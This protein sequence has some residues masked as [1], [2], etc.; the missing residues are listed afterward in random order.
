MLK[1]SY[2]E[3][4]KPLVQTFCESMSQGCYQNLAL[5]PMPFLPLFGQNYESSALRLLIIGQDTRS[6]GNTEHFIQTETESPGKMISAVFDEIEHLNFRGWGKSTNSF[7]GF[8]MALLANIHNLPDWKV[9]KGQEGYQGILSSFAWANSFAVELWQSLNKH[10]KEV[11]YDTWKAAFDAGEHFNRL[12]HMIATVS[13]RVVILTAKSPNLTRFFE[14][15]DW[16]KIPNPQDGLQQYRFDKHNVDLFHTYH[17][18][19]MRNV[20][21]PWSFLNKIRKS[22]QDSGISPAFPEFVDDSEQSSS[23]VTFLGNSCPRPTGFHSDIYSFIAWT[24]EEL[25]KRQAFMSV[26]TLF[27]L[28]N[29]IGYRT[30]YGSKYSGGRGSYRTVRLAYQRYEQD[31]PR[32]AEMIAH[33]FRKPDFTYAY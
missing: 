1:E 31:N 22:L 4:Y 21:G 13:P 20:G 15:L 14:G 25:A 18:N 23:V 28:A 9:L 8:T 3:Y 16:R 32:A 11:P 30:T 29:E 24:A 19:Y 26:P 2:L 33:A 7:W 5:M 17:P 10:T 6:W 27:H 12:R